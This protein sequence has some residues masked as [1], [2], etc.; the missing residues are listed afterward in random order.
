MYSVALVQNQ[1]EMS[2]YGYADMRPMLEEFGYKIK[3]YTA[4][5]INNLSSDLNRLKFDG[6]VLATNALNDKTIR[7]IFYSESF[8][9]SFTQFIKKGRGCLILHQLRIAQEKERL[10]FLPSELN[11]IL[12]KERKKGE[13][14]IQGNLKLTS[15]GKKNVC[16]LYPNIINISEIKKQCITFKGLKGIY[17]HYWDNVENSDWDV[18][19]Y[20][21]DSDGFERALVINSKEFEGYRIVLSS[22]ALDW[23]KQKKLLQNILI[24]T[25][26]GRHNTAILKNSKKTITG[27]EYFIESLNAQKYPFRIYEIDQTLEDFITNVENGIHKIVLFGPSVQQES[28]DK[29]YGHILKQNVEKG[30]IKLINVVVEN[31]DL[32]KFYISGSERYALRLLN[33]LELDIQRELIKGYIDG[34][35]WSSVESLQIMDA[36]KSY[37][38]SRYDTDAIK[39]VL[40]KAKLHDHDG[41]YDEVFGVSCA[42]LWLRATYLGTTH[43]D[44]QRTLRWIRQNISDYEDREKALAYSTLLSIGEANKEEEKSLKNLL[45]SLK[46]KI[47]F[48]SEIDLI[49]Y[50]KAAVLINCEEIIFPLIDRLEKIQKYGYWVDLATTASAV[51][52][53]LDSLDLLKREKYGQDTLRSKVEPMIFKSII[54]IQN[55]KGEIHGETNNITYPWD[56]KASTSLKC[57]Q[58]WLKFE[59]LIDFPVHELI[60][61]LKSYSSIEVVSSTN[62]NSLII[63]DELRTDNKKLAQKNME[64][65]QEREKDLLQIEKSKRVLRLNKYLWVFAFANLYILMSI[66]SYSLIIGTN[67]PIS[68][69]FL[70][71]FAR[72]WPF[73]LMFLTFIVSVFGLVSRWKRTDEEVS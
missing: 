11:K 66:V 38:I 39:H 44:T 69:I 49:V 6:I 24:Y 2:H 27:F 10:S 47:E 64:L 35:F 25:I 20:D 15:I 73:H 40:E 71:V 57:I 3:L 62:K 9:S 29:K 52:T 42:L 22:L 45:F 1:S 59:E 72:G 26:E 37:L 14:A 4:Q 68:N 17:W 67:T 56:N 34:S 54:Y 65:V 32:K 5:N 50:L 48:S 60:E 36:L 43:K 55:S 70:D 7:E 28:I 30:N 53:L 31:T 8:K 41:S 18:L 46:N 16:F 58:A 12:P 19:L 61:A 33:G 51:N 21:T 63:L 23:Q 13:R